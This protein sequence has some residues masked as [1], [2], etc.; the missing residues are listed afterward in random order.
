MCPP[1]GKVMA[2]I[3]HNMMRKEHNARDARDIS[4]AGNRV[5]S[6]KRL[7]ACFLH[8]FDSQKVLDM[9]RTGVVIFLP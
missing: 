2:Q 8:E 4:S 3:I 5:F 6:A 7:L 9:G 1:A